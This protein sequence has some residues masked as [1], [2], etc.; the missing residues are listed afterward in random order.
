MPPS[1]L[2]ALG[3][4][5]DNH[6]CHPRLQRRPSRGES[7]FQHWSDGM[8]RIGEHVQELADHVNTAV[9]A[10]EETENR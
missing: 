8:H 9:G 3:D 10:Y 6:D 4:V 5:R 2:T 7:F 1:E